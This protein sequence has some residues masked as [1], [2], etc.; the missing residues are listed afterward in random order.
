MCGGG[1]WLRGRVSNL[2]VMCAMCVCVGGM[3]K[4]ERWGMRE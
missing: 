4:G 3:V 1:E 2:Y